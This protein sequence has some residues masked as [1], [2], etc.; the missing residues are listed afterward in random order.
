MVFRKSR[1][2]KAQRIGSTALS[3]VI[4]MIA[5]ACSDDDTDTPPVPSPPPPPPPPPVTMVPEV[6]LQAIGVFETGIFDEGAAEIVAFDPGTDQ[7]F[8]INS[9]DTTV[10]ILDLTDPTAP[11]LVD[12]IDASALG[13]GAN[14]VA[15]SGDMFAV[16]IEADDATDPG[17]V[18]F[19]NASSLEL[20]GTVTVGALPDMVTFTPDGQTVL[21]ANEGEVSDD[22]Q[23]NPVGS[24][25]VIDISSGVATAVAETADFLEFNDDRAELIAAGVRLNQP[26]F[27]GVADPLTVDVS[28]L[29]PVSVAQDLE[30]EFIA[31]AP[32]GTTAFVSLQENNAFA[33]VDIEQVAVT[34]I[35]SFGTVDH[36]IAGNEFDPNDDDGINI[37]NAPVRGLRMP[38]AIAVYEVDGNVFMVTANEGDGREFEFEDPATGDDEVVF[39]DVIDVDDGVAEGAF[40]ASLD[41]AALTALNDLEVSRTDGDADGDGDIDE[42]FAFGSRSFS[43]IDPT[44]T[45]VFDSGSMFET[46]TADL[47]PDDFNSTNDENGSFENR[48]DDA[49]PEPEGVTIGVIDGV[50]LAFIGLERIGGIMVYDITDPT[51]VAFEDYINVRD[52]TVDVTVD[53]DGDGEGDSTNSA[54]GDLGPEGLAF[55]SAADSPS[56]VP[57]LAVGNEVSGTTRIFQVN[58][59]MVPES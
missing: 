57:L 38:D 11:A 48:S 2:R 30:P 54:A 3:A 43:I 26:D 47:F 19:F 33:V 58:L 29:P 45:V 42:I 56:G 51:A 39:T 6:T 7:L 15:V 8:V 52:F 4:L 14:S 9:N 41:A 28:T 12:Q 18:A 37:V 17:L 44:G 31:V 55:I 25:S 32:D 34:E 49:G 21:V 24:V 23:T 53:D 10:D 40:D 16:A 22:L 20:D 5:A 36:S 59:E 1:A 50:T 46:M 35:I 27:N 13:G